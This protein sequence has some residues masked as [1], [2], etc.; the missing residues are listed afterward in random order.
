MTDA[1]YKAFLSF[2]TH[3]RIS[4]VF[5]VVTNGVD[6]SHNNN[7]A[8]KLA[9]SL[10]YIRMV[11]TLIRLGAQVLPI[12]DELLALVPD[13][14]RGRLEQIFWNLEAGVESRNI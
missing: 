8:V 1:H 7:E 6:I 5:R 9:A 3:N 11:K 13:T 14:Q 10:G 2:V 12:K 4:D